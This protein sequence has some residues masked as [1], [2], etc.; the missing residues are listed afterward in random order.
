FELAG[1]LSL[2]AMRSDWD[3]AFA[4]WTDRASGQLWSSAGASQ[5]GVDRSV[6]PLVSLNHVPSRTARFAIDTSALASLNGTWL[7]NDK[8]SFQLVPTGGAAMIVATRES[9]GEGCVAGGY[10]APKLEI[11]FCP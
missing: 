6:A 4:N 10:S 11:T 5:I 2:F 9:P 7:Q 8:L 3:E 1:L